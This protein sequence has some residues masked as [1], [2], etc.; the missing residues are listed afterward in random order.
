MSTK[1]NRMSFLHRIAQLPAEHVIDQVARNLGHVLGTRKGCGSVVAGFGLGDYERCPNT[2]EAVAALEDE[3]A[4]LARRYEPRLGDPEV[5]L[6]GRLGP[7][8]ICFALTGRVAGEA[9][10]LHITIH[11]ELRNVIVAIA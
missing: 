2:I 11:T 6:L 5:R 1:A 9:C 7:S 10:T 8:R 3:I 4:A